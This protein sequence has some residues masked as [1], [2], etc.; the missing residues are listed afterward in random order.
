MKTIQYGLSP[1]VDDSN[2]GEESVIDAVS[3]L[4]FDGQPLLF[5]REALLL[6]FAKASIPP[7]ASHILVQ[8]QFF[9]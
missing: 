7:I 6:Q 4:V 5:T 2:P 9:M 8:A 3:I 1:V